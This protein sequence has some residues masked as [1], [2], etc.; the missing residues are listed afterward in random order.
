M[1]NK[2][3]IGA[4]A[5]AVGIYL[6][7]KKKGAST[8][9]RNDESIQGISGVSDKERSYL[10]ELNR[11][12]AGV[13]DVSYDLGSWLD[14]LRNFESLSPLVK[15]YQIENVESARYDYITAIQSVVRPLKD[16]ID[17]KRKK[18]K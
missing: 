17:G 5:A 9:T 13:E 1:N 18:K 16:A 3:L 14:E 15:E 2:L 7:T 8:N 4:A 6:L 10:M 12:Q 11:L